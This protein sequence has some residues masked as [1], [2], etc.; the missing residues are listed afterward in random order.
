M[1]N[2]KRSI[3]FFYFFAFEITLCI[4]ISIFLLFHVPKPSIP[5][6]LISS[7]ILIDIIKQSIEN[8]SIN[9]QTDDEKVIFNTYEFPTR[10]N[11]ENT[12][13]SRLIRSLIHDSYESYW[14]KC[15]TSDYLRPISE[16]CLNSSGLSFTVIESLESLYLSELM[17][18]YKFST[19]FVFNK[20]TCSSSRFQNFH[21]M[22]TRVLGSLIGIYSLTKNHHFIDKAVECADV[23]NHAFTSSIPHPLVDGIKQ[24]AKKYSFIDGTFLSESSGFILEYTALS[25]ITGD[26]VYSSYVQNYLKCILS[27]F[28]AENSLPSFVSV[29][30]CRSIQKL[31][32]KDDL[33]NI[34]SQLNEYTVSF[35]ANVIRLHLFSPSNLTF[36]I[37]DFISDLIS[38]NSQLQKDKKHQN[39][40]LFDSSFCQ[41]SYLMEKVPKLKSSPFY[42]NL[43]NICESITENNFPVQKSD[44]S[45]WPKIKVKN[46]SFYF[47][48]VPLIGSNFSEKSKNQLKYVNSLNTTMC[49]S[50]QC[51]LISQD[52]IVYDDIM[53]TELLSKWLKFLYLANSS[54]IDFSKNNWII[55][56]A[57]H[58]IITDAI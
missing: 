16:G 37:I 55:N 44:L 9:N 50:A 47:D 40:Y 56:E 28:R 10:K 31:N 20:F 33:I 18:D 19:D 45:E 2:K 54:I 22:G 21:E 8:F 29:D 53:P 57:G 32:K 39:N 24:K 46:D 23:M 5:S 13:T 30:K 49:N 43:K 6:Q 3:Y 42:N 36:E 48:F 11:N 41:L 52:P 51:A 7:S 4:L 34:F 25:K 17:D 15:S 14:S 1:R 26:P 38:Q 58:L 12:E 27:L 35:V